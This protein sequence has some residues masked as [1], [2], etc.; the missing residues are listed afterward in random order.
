MRILLLNPNL[1]T[2]QNWGHQLFKN[3]IGETTRC[4]LLWRR[5]FGIQ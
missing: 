1:I 3:E 4:F 5:L 2:R